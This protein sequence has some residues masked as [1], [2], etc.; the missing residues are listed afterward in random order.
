MRAR[1]SIFLVTVL[2][3]SALT[4]AATPALA[5]YKVEMAAA[6]PPEELAP[7]VRESLAGDVVRVV[8]P[9]GSLCE[10]WL[11]KSVPAQASSGPG[12]GVA[13]PQLAVG[14][15]VGAVRFAAETRDYRRQQ[16][17]PGV[18]TLRYALNPADGNHMG[19]APQRDF[20]ILAPAAEDTKTAAISYE[21]VLELSRKASGTNHPSVWSLEPADERVSA[22]KLIH[23]EEEDHWV[24]LFGV[25][26]DAGGS[27]TPATL[28]LVIVGFAAEA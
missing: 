27:K 19:V 18:Y 7:A 8:G 6:A 24:L 3:F 28:G 21:E 4:L 25:S 26:L 17:K 15:L 20:L 10:V 23:K 14:T 9:Q 5:Q 16:V 13:F 1:S 2:L 12:I 11:R 22:P